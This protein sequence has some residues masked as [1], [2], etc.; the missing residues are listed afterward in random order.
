MQKTYFL[1]YAQGN[2]A[3]PD[4]SGMRHSMPQ[5]HLPEWGEEDERAFVHQIKT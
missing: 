3:T 4:S 2:Y 5:R 1:W